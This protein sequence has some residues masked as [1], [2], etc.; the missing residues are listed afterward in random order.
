[1]E[2]HVD[3]D[4]F[5]S[6]SRILGSLAAD[7]SLNDADG[8]EESR[9]RDVPHDRTLDSMLRRGLTSG[10]GSRRNASDSRAKKS[11]RA[12]EGGIE[13]RGRDAKKAGGCASLGFSRAR[14][15]RASIFPSTWEE[16]ERDRFPGEVAENEVFPRESSNNR[17]QVEIQPSR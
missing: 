9:D 17:R 8:N 5:E 16:N 6:I 1:M 13:A 12:L 11:S 7:N 15:W 2:N 3:T 14:A 10:S 4:S